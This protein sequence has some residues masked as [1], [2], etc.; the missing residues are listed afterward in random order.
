[1]DLISLIKSKTRLKILR[2]FFL[3]KDKKYYLRELERILSLSV[4]NIRR[5]LI[6]LEKVGLFNREKMGNLV[7][8]SLNKTSPLFEVLKKI[9]SKK[10]TISEV[11]KKLKKDENMNL[12]IVKKA[13]L[14]SLMS[15]MNE[16]HNIIE[17]FLSES[18]EVEDLI[19]LGVVV[20]NRGKVLLMK[21]L[22]HKEGRDKAVLTWGFPDG[23]Q[24]LNES[25]NE[26]V[27]RG[28]LERTGYRV[29]SIKEISSRF[30][31]Q[32]PVFIVYHLC[33]LILPKPIAKPKKGYEIAEI[34][35]VRPE[36]ISKL[37]TTDFNLEVRRELGLK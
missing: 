21:W 17:N 20:N 29:K 3:N 34:K 16:L 33:K 27:A 5:E 30:H 25:R 4:G 37:F 22:G 14:Y 23:T 12:M 26:C 13:E 24:R 32:F 6:A 19:N 35:W 31:P 8:Y 28:V 36:E 15:K 7:Y 11:K 9:I 10:G 2:F 1:M 18:L